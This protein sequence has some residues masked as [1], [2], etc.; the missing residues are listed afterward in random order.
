MQVWHHYH[1]C[2]NQGVS[3]VSATQVHTKTA[4]LNRY[5]C[6]DAAPMY[7]HLHLHLYLHHC[8]IIKRGDE[9]LPAQSYLDGAR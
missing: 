2:V 9:S 7:S 1:Q 6:A 5:L 8:K 3:I 4:L